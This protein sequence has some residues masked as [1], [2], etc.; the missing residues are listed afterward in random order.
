M[1]HIVR[2]DDSRFVVYDLDDQITFNHRFFDRSL[3]EAVAEILDRDQKAL[4]AH[5]AKQI[6]EG[7][8]S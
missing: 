2:N 6:A 7:G 4:I 3:A 8:H 1:A 5:R